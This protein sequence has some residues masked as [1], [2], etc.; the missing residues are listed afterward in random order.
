[1]MRSM[2]RVT[3]TSTIGP[4]IAAKRPSAAPMTNETAITEKPMNSDTRAP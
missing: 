2:S 4:V 3:A 1:M